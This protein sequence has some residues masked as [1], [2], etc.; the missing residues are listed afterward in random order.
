MYI[1]YATDRI[2]SDSHR[3]QGIFCAAYRLKRN[4]RAPEPVR[5]EIARQLEWFHT[6]L[7]VPR[8]WSHYSLRRKRRRIAI[9]WFKEDASEHLRRIA[10]MAVFLREQCI[11]IYELKTRH[12][13]YITYEDDYQV[14][15]VPFRETN[16]TP[17]V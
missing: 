10:S 1:R 9:C 13:G 15:A 14:A 2:D 5:A 4:E 3:T 7:P 17:P 16:L 8:R 11:E 6:H 12:A